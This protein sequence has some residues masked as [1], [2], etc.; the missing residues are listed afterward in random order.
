V[1][2]ANQKY[3][4]FLARH[5]RSDTVQDAGG[6]KNVVGIADGSVR[7]VTLLNWL[8]NEQYVWGGP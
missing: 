3:N 2:S 8:S 6:D 1:P 4:A 7:V 5:S